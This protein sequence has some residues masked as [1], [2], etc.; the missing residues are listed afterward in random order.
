MKR[1][2]LFFVGACVTTV[3]FGQQPQQLWSNRF[4]GTGD[5]SQEFS[6]IGA[7]SDGSYFAGG[8]AV[9]G[10]KQKDLQIA[11]L[12]AKGDT[13]W[14]KYLNGSAGK[15]DG[16]NDLVVDSM[17]NVILCGYFTE[18]NKGKDLVV[19][20]LSSS[21]NVIWTYQFNN[22]N[23]SNDDEGL[24]IATDG[25]GHYY[26]TGSTD[27]EP[28]S[29]TNQNIITVKLDENGKVVWTK[30]Y[31]GSGEFDDVPK[32]IVAN[33]KGEVFVCGNTDNGSD[34]DMIT[35]KY[36]TNGS[37][38]WMK[39]HNKGKNDEASGI[40]IDKGFVYVAGTSDNGREREFVLMKYSYSG[41]ESWPN[42]VS[43]NGPALGND[44]ATNVLTDLSGNVYICGMSDQDV[45]SGENMDFCIVK[46]N[47]NGTEQWVKTWGS[48]KEQRDV[49]SFLLF[50]ADNELI[51]GG[52]ADI[53]SN[54]EYSSG[55]FQAVAYTTSGALLWEQ[56]YS[57]SNGY[58]HCADGAID[59]NGS[60]AITGKV[61]VE[62]NSDNCVLLQFNSEGKFNFYKEIEASGENTDRVHQLVMD[63]SGNTYLCGF[64]FDTD[65]Q[66]DMFVQ[67]AD[68]YG[69]TNW[70]YTYHGKG[71]EN[72][73]AMDLCVDANG[74]TYVTGY[75]KGKKSDYDVTTLK[76]APDGMLEWEVHYDYL[77][78][79]GD[80]RGSK[81]VLDSEGNIYVAGTSDGDAG[82][83]TDLDIVLLKYNPKGILIWNK[84][85]AGKA[86][87]DESVSGLK[88]LSGNRIVLSGN[89]FNG[90]DDDILILQYNDAGLLQWENYH[91]GNIGNDRSASLTIDNGE[92][93]TVVGT[94]F[95]GKDNDMIA[96]Q[97]TAEG[98]QNWVNQFDGGKNEEG[99]AAA[100]DA[101]RNIY[102][103]GTS[104][105]EK[106]SDVVVLKMSDNGVTNWVDTY[107]GADDL[108]DG[109]AS[110]Q[111]DNS[112][113]IVVA[114]YSE[115]N[116]DRPQSDLL[117]RKYH[118]NFGVPVWNKLLDGGDKLNDRAYCLLIDDKNNLYIAGSSASL[119]G[120]E[121]IV[122][123]K[124]D[125][126]LNLHEITYPGTGINLFPNPFTDEIT[127]DLFNDKGVLSF[128][129]IYSLNGK[130]VKSFKTTKS[131]FVIDK[132]VVK[133]GVY[134]YNVTQDSEVVQTGKIILK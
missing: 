15:N 7:A 132:K 39:S 18:V 115:I 30:F 134:L 69:F 81:I 100:A 103:T 32:S 78:A 74:N 82:S 23:A 119:K 72:D 46:Y 104:F 64:T 60:L 44:I 92:K 93:I 109:V 123:M 66:R 130:K 54:K 87:G 22:E 11:R 117:L 42:G 50:G 68:T 90:T 4:N 51:I 76:I 131:E 107:N 96:L 125:S 62:G 21:G 37:L 28:G 5:F 122:S 80:D 97:Y 120:Q 3:S 108:N 65:G 126:P 6:S 26:V 106:N 47:I 128:I 67:R 127:I 121:D 105:G 91:N 29:K 116:K 113:F 110:I 55:D 57:V 1:F 98:V 133:P 16:L 85:F 88:C 83:K 101:S 2:L 89:T 94:S 58:A 53:S 40:A 35:L 102:V 63:A 124:F 61:R 70:K 19:M 77:N 8:F 99:V 20:K 111:V 10:G 12:N 31:D 118:P 129:D 25:G 24:S 112:D 71:E 48:T 59:K 52:T 27:T 17:N 36:G 9:R 56:S 86:A 84:R 38:A 34:L 49:P 41:S 45:T 75:S 79:H 43:F 14:C 73:E 95:N 13:I 114:G 33:N